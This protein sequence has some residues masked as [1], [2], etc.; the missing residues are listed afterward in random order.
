M[1]VVE[2][3]Q[4]GVFANV[5]ATKA[6]ELG[7]RYVDGYVSR[8]GARRRKGDLDGAIADATKAIE[9]DQQCAFAWMLRG[10]ARR[11]KGA[12][13]AAAVQDLERYLGLVPGSDPNVSQV[14]AIL[15]QLKA[16]K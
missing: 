4:T 5:V 8:G 10:L 2:H 1:A 12:D 9:L 6:L 14:R 16:R 13:L 11:E 7:P 3:G 15:E